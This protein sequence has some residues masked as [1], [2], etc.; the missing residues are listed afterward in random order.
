MRKPLAHGMRSR[1]A[2]VARAVVLA[3]LL[4]AFCLPFYWMIVCSL[5]TP[6]EIFSSHPALIPDMG[7]LANYRRVL[8]DTGFATY[9]VNSLVVCVADTALVTLCTILASYAVGVLRLRHGEA[10][11]NVLTFFALVPSELLVIVNLRTVIE[12]GVYDT[13]AAIFIPFIANVMYARMLITAF[14]DMPAPYRQQ[15]LVDGMGDWTFLWRVAVPSVMPSI[16]TIMG[17]NAIASWNSFVWPMYA[18]VSSE[19]MTVPFGLYFFTT[20]LSSSPEL[21]MAASVLS[22]LPALVIMW[23]I[24]GRLMRDREV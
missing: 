6:E 23:M 12:L 8:E 17:L 20:E 21:I 3:L 10:V 5:S 14:R 22:T 7:G 24:G 1:A 16:V 9:F 15:A 13:L 4:V 11:I 19:N 2:A 18:I